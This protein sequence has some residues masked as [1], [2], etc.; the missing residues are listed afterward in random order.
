[1]EIFLSYSSKDKKTAGLVKSRM[2]RLGIDSFLAH[3]DI[4][5]TSI[6]LQAILKHLKSCDIFL[7]II[8]SDFCSSDWTGQETG[9]AMCRKIPIIPVD[10]GEKPKGFINKYQALPLD[11]KDLDSFCKELIGVIMAKSSCRGELLDIL[12]VSFGDSHSFDEAGT[13]F[14]LLYEHRSHLSDVQV[15]EIFKLAAANQQIHF[16]SSARRNL[17]PFV[18]ENRDKV[19]YGIFKDL[20]E[21]LSQ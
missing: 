6:W 12:I 20:K 16:S 10:A 5:P 18:E 21:K 17:V 1:M 4:E 7:A 15:K 19:G 9:F 8:T 11:S 3:E 2:K 14:S 13:N